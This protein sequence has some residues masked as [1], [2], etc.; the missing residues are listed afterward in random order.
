VGQVVFDIVYCAGIWPA[1]QPPQLI[2]NVGYLLTISP[3]IEQQARARPLER[4]I[5]KL[6]E[7]IGTAA[8]INGDMGYIAQINLGCI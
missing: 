4:H 3:S 1:R 5:T 7:K 6:A 2:G 8:A